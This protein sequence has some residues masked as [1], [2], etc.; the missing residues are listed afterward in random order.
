M[1]KQERIWERNRKAAVKL[2]NPTPV[3]LP[4]HAWR[5]QVTLNG[6]RVG[7]TADTPEDAH[8]QALAAKVGLIEAQM[9]NKTNLSLDDAIQQ[10]I[11]SLEIRRSP[12]TIRG[13]DNIRRNHFKDIINENIY[14]L[15]DSKLKRAVDRELSAYSVKTVKNDYG[16]IHAVLTHFDLHPPEMD[17][18][19]EFKPPKHYLQPA[20][21][22]KLIDAVRGDLCEVPILLAVWLGMR[23]SEICGLC[24]DCVDMEN[25]IITVS[26]A[27]VPDKHHKWVLKDYPKTSA[28]QR[29][30]DC[31]P[32]IMDKLTEQRLSGS[33]G[34]VFTLHPDTI[35]R[36]T[37]RAC[38]RA[39]ITD[40][41]VHGLRHTNAAVMMK[42]GIDDRQAMERGG[43]SNLK[44]YQDT[45]SYMFDKDEEKGNK[46]IN[47][48][49]ENCTRN[50]TRK[51]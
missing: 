26:R 28:S 19:K 23:R 31:P 38:E 1:T 18:P 6:K 17:Y 2:S 14:T 50:C 8:A 30:V 15:T 24:W 49:F 22:G 33:T 27:L 7:F 48:F 36:H 40:S 29:T 43:W 13:Y 5:C 47:N 32:Y 45:Y 4:S 25:N 37:H 3:E 39:G 21:V 20:D 46:K 10:Y 9:E 44:T 12:A 34:R 11:D 51:K 35:R 41:T 42:L 16:L